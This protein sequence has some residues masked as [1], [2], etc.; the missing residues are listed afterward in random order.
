MFIKSYD[1]S[2]VWLQ[3]VNVLKSHGPIFLCHIY[4]IYI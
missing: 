4:F 3:F 1:V 2:V